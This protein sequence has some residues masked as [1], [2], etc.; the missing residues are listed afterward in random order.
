MQ[1]SEGLQG[2]RIDWSEG[3]GFHV[4]WWDR[5][6]GLKRA[7]WYYGANTVE[8]GTYVDYLNLL[9]HFPEV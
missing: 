1:S 8:G 7:V 6:G 3:S 5:T 4:N 2:W 9:S